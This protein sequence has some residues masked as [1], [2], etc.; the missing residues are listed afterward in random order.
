V[1]WHIAYEPIQWRK[2]FHRAGLAS[3]EVWNTVV[4]GS[5]VHEICNLL[6]KGRLIRWPPGSRDIWITPFGMEVLLN[7]TPQKEKV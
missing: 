4:T 7:G 6:R 5:D 3:M 1:L 2:Y